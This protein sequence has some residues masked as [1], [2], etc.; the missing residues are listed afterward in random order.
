MKKRSIIISGHATSV[1]VE[2]EFWS[3]L[4]KIALE[5][6]KSVSETIASI[7]LLPSSTTNL[8][9]KIRLYVLHYYRDKANEV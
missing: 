7:D 1:T 2:D 8:S 9:S 3:A 5:H 6:K 4:K